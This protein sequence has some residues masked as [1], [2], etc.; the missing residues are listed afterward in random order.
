M[1]EE[2]EQCHWQMAC[3]GLTHTYERIYAYTEKGYFACLC[4]FYHFYSRNG[5]QSHFSLFSSNFS[6]FL[7]LK[8]PSSCVWACMCVCV[9]T[10]PLCLFFWS[11]LGG[12]FSCVYVR[13]VPYV[14]CSGVLWATRVCH[15]RLTHVYLYRVTRILKMTKSGV[16]SEVSAFF[17]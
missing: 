11:F 4:H 5:S 9:Y 10:R 7:I 8:T 6:S 17:L 3:Y 2:M 13:G 15:D 14:A 1:S 16:S 12:A